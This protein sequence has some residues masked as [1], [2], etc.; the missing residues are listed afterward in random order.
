MRTT[1]LSSSVL[2]L[3]AAVMAMTSCCTAPKSNDKSSAKKQEGTPISVVGKA[4][5]GKISALVI[6]DKGVVYMVP[7]LGRWPDDAR[8]KR[9]KV[10]GRFVQDDRYAAKAV[11]GVQEQGTAGNDRIILKAKYE[12]V[13]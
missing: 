10:T 8:N 9:V 7:S 4:Q 6:D 13:K 2:V 1:I 12:V 5:D 11:D 3:C